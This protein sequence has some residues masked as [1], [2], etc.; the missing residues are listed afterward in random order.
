MS[1]LL[2]V[3]EIGPSGKHFVYLDAETGTGVMTPGNDGHVHDVIYDP[4]RDPVEATPAMLIDPNT[5]E[6]MEAPVLE[7]GSPD[8][9][10]IQE[11]IQMGL[12]YQEGNP[13]DPGKEEGEWI[14]APAA[15]KNGE[16]HEHTMSEYQAPESTTQED[17]KTILDECKLL[18]REW[19][20]NES[21]CIKKGRESEDFFANKQW[22]DQIKRTLE[23]NDRAALTINEIAPA[24]D[25]LIGYQMEQRTELRYLPQEGGDQRAADMYNVIVKSFLDRSYYQREKTKVFKDICVAG[26]GILKVGVR[27]DDD[28]Q[29]LPFVQ[30]FQWDEGVYGPFENEDLSDCEGSVFSRMESIA[31]L[32]KHFGK[33]AEKIQENFDSYCGQYPDIG[34]IDSK[35]LV[36]GANTDYRQARKVDDTNM[37][38]DGEVKLVDIQKKQFRFVEVTRKVYKEVTV[39][40]N[41]EDQFFLTAYD[42]GEK[43]IELVRQLPG[44]EVVT[45]I[46]PRMRITKFCG[47]V[48]LS[49]ENPADLPMH[50]F[51]SVPAFAY[52]QNGEYWGKVEAAKDPQREL[53][54]RRSQI[55]DQANRMSAAV[56][57]T[58]PNMFTTKAEE[59][60]FDK[61]RSSPG[62]RFNVNDINRI[63]HVQQGAEIPVSLVNIMQ[64]DQ[65]NLQRLLNVVVQQGGANESGA[66]FLERKKTILGG[67]QFLIDNLSFAEQK[68]GKLLLAM[69]QRYYPPERCL[70]ILNAQYSRSKFKVGGEDYSKYTEEEVIEIL[71][72]SDTLDYDVIVADSALAPSTRLGIAQMLLEAMQKGAEIP[73]DLVFSF[74][75]VPADV[76]LQIEEKLA[77]QQEA[78]M[79]AEANSSN[80]E[81]KKT[82][83]AKG[84]YTISPEEAQGMGLVPANQGLPNGGQVPNNEVQ[85]QSVDYTQNL[86]DP[87]AA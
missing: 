32:K 1:K 60:R 15:N 83:L 53:N 28:I 69:V 65:Q 25:T 8:E 61:K 12:Q 86:S 27:F 41:F 63:P 24:I 62:S 23:A 20:Q 34:R 35:N 47:D 30:R 56:Y 6:Q 33:K 64:L 2:R 54:K 9:A 29:G 10:A 39:I 79:Q 21:D 70:R 74:M 40:Y 59:Q 38:L 43:D 36:S 7:D 75:D 14:I 73:M 22:P 72:C 85:G 76:K 18:W 66:L 55:M 17:D 50:D 46:R 57:F 19:R 5:G 31:W 78:A 42:W 51:F 11:A 48:V 81:I 52:R 49:D 26:K 4:P 58:E 87:L 44:F 16:M 37:T 82:V 71:E 13:G 84:E 45:Q 3:T 77:A 68:L 67:N 80:T